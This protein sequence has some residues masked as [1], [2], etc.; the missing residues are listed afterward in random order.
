MK[1]HLKKSGV[2]WYCAGRGVT[3]MSWTPRLAYLEWVAMVGTQ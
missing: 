1:P 3:S 2:L